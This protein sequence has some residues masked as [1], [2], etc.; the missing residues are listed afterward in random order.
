M[1]RLKVILTAFFLSASVFAQDNLN[2]RADNILGEYHS[3]YKQDEGRFVFTKNSDGTYDCT[4]TWSKN[5]VDPATGKKYLDVK[6]PDKSL[7]DTPCDRIKIIKGLRYNAE[8]KQWDDARIYDP[9]RGITAKVTVKFT[10]DGRL[11]L[12][13]SVLG[14]GET[15]YWDKL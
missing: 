10:S 8:K 13:G 2:E 7:R 12:R 4:T 5:S 11:S 3:V 6:N 14:I 9:T 15:V 1:K